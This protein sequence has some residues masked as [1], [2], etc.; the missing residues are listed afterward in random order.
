MDGCFLNIMILLIL[1]N[2]C[3]IM[4]KLK[5]IVID[6]YYNFMFFFLELYVLYIFICDL[7]Y[8]VLCSFVLFWVVD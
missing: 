7:R 8:I 4:F 1:I 2:E 6:Y 3:F 5:N